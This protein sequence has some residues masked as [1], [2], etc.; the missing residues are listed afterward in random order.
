MFLTFFHLLSLE[1]PAGFSNK[2][3]VQKEVK[4]AL[5]QKA[6]LSCEVSDSTI[7]V[8]WFKDGKVLTSSNG[9]HMESKGKTRELVIERMEKKDAGEYTCEA[10][11]EKLVFTLQLTGTNIS[12][13]Y[14][15]KFKQPMIIS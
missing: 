2:E 7:E 5:S 6:T 12:Q 15:Y 1:P 3:S 10:G 9:V 4:A 8:K 13:I 11:N 14:V